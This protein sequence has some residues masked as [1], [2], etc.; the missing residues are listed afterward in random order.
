MVHDSDEPLAND[1]GVLCIVFNNL[2]REIFIIL[3]I[4]YTN[5]KFL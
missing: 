4:C 5:I 3:Q 2:Y 1:N